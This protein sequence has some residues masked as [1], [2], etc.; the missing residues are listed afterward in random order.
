ME[1]SIS[2]V[3]LKKLRMN[4]SNESYKLCFR[5]LAQMHFKLLS[6]QLFRE[7]LK[8]VFKD[9][10]DLLIEINP[11]LLDEYQFSDEKLGEKGRDY[12]E[13][14][15]FD[16][17]ID[18]IT[19]LGKRMDSVGFGIFFKLVMLHQ[20]KVIDDAEFYKSAC[21]Y[22][23]DDFHM[24]KK[25]ENVLKYK[26]T[27]SYI[28]LPMIVDALKNNDQVLNN[29]YKIYREKSCESSQIDE[30]DFYY[31]YEPDRVIRESRKMP[32]LYKRTS[33][34][35]QNNEAVL[36]WESRRTELDMVLSM[37]TLVEEELEGALRKMKSGK[38]IMGAKLRDYL[39]EQGVKVKLLEK[40]EFKKMEKLPLERLHGLV[41]QLR[42][43]KEEVAEAIRQLN[44]RRTKK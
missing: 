26:T 35:E 21:K 28:K 44:L 24:I 25:L 31:I 30:D 37:L 32:S 10:I 27:P 15:N 41:N 12:S 43:K 38:W 16:A 18:F 4:L 3:V 20:R 40:M 29:T 8:F 7:K 33:F 11:L 2:K 17:S 13:L 34:D 1:S 14:E 23:K 36:W 6:P 5:L 22:L 19:E 9:Q 42:L 39:V